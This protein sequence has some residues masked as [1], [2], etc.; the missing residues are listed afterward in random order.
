MHW[1][2]PPCYF[3][4][5]R[6]QIASC[7]SKFSVGVRQTWGEQS[8]AGKGWAVTSIQWKHLCE[9][10]LCS[11]GVTTKTS[12]AA[13]LSQSETSAVSYWVILYANV[14]TTFEIEQW[15]CRD[16]WWAVRVPAV[17]LVSGAGFRQ[18]W[19]PVV[20]MVLYRNIKHE[21]A[22][23]EE[24]S[25]CFIH[26]LSFFKLILKDWGLVG[27]RI[28]CLRFC[29]VWGSEETVLVFLLILWDSRW[30]RWG[31]WASINT[32]CKHDTSMW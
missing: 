18:I 31:S 28:F 12:G 10:H 20:V 15:V 6:W 13:C 23:Q 26:S 1:L 8:A 27:T 2:P 21:G 17:N 32:L 14:S 25:N 30:N 7:S 19:T 22:F 5:I 29:P 9:I 11:A 24:T 16:Q 4:I 3:C